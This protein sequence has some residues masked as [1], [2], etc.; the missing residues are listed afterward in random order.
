[1]APEI[2][3]HYLEGTLPEK[4]TD[5]SINIKQDIYSL[6]LILYQLS[7]K[8]TTAQQWSKVSKILKNERRLAVI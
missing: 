2:Q 4:F 1:M 7:F 8:I 5:V 6:G 3:K